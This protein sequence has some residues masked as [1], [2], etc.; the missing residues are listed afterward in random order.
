MI[1]QRLAAAVGVLMI[2][3]VG[4]PGLAQTTRATPARA[5]H[6]PW[7]EPDLTGMWTNETI[8]PF[9]RP[10]N[11]AGKAFLTE[12]EA[13]AIEARAATQREASDDRAPRAGDVG[14]YN[15]F[16]MD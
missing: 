7:G 2:V 8:T 13:K 1:R 14:N 10:A 12:E 9:E 11:L 5:P 16:W 15:Q 3:S 6:T 4:I